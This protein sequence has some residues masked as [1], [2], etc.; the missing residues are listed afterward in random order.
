VLERLRDDGFSLICLL[1]SLPFLQPMSLGPISLAAGASLTVLGLQKARGAHTPWLPEKMA[2]VVLRAELWAVM[3]KT[4]ERVL[5]LCRRVARPRLTRLA[6]GDF[7]HRLGGYIVAAS[8]VLIAAPLPGIPFSNSLPA[9]AVLF[10]SVAELEEDGFFMIAS[11]VAIVATLVYFA[12]VGTVAAAVLVR[13]WC[14]LLGWM[15]MTSAVC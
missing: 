4:C 10:V 15:S 6:T 12:L 14:W 13:I 11:W 3:L 5:R 7:A 2:S 1:H 8:G 9:L